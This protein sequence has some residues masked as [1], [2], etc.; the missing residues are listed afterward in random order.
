MASPGNRRLAYLLGR[1]FPQIEADFAHYYPGTEP[2]ELWQRRSWR[3][4]LN[5]IDHLP[6]NSHYGQ[7]VADDEE[8]AKMILAAQR[9]AEKQGKKP[10]PYAPPLTSWSPER[11]TLTEILDAIRGLAVV[12]A[13]VQGNHLPMPKPSPRPRTAFDRV[14]HRMRMEQHESLVARVKAAQAQAAADREA[15]TVE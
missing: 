5:L 15:G 6:R 4:L 11:E 1:Y 14:Q 3:R 13:N 9:E 10:P 7:A 2:I 8:H 12:T